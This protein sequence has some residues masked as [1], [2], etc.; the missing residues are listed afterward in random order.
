M[1]TVYDYTLPEN[2]CF[3]VKH[4]ASDYVVSCTINDEEKQIIIEY[5]SIKNIPEVKSIIFEEYNKFGILVKST[6]YEFTEIINKTDTEI[7]YT[8]K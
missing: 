8:Y 5:Y 7:T 6:K 4:I 2:N 1:I 3:I